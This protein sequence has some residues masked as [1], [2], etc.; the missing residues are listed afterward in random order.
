M[1]PRGPESIRLRKVV[2]PRGVGR[3]CRRRLAML[4]RL[5][6]R[7][8]LAGDPWP[9]L[10]LLPACEWRAAESGLAAEAVPQYVVHQPPRLQPG[11][12]PLAGTPADTGRDQIDI[13]WQT[14]TV[15]AGTSDDFLV[16]FRAPTDATWT[17]VSLNPVLD[18]GDDTRL[19]HSA[20]LRDLEWDADYDY[21]VDHRRLGALVDRYEH[22]FHTRLAT[23]DSRS[24]T[25]VAYGDSAAPGLLGDGFRAVQSRINDSDAAFAVLLGDNIYEFGTH[26]EAD[27][28]FTP[29][30]NLAA[31]SWIAGHVD[32]FA[33]G[34]HDAIINFH[35]GQPSRDSYSSPQPVAGLNAYAAPPAGEFPE[36]NYSWDYGDV[37][38]V[39]IDTNVV[40]LPTAADRLTRTRAM[41]DY[42]VAD[43][44]ASSARWKIVSTHHP[45]VGSEKSYD[46]PA[47]FY[48]QE[49]LPR[50]RAAGA[51]LLLAGD[52]HTYS[53]TYPL[54]GFSDANQDGQIGA[55]EVDYV[56]DPD[57]EY[58][59]GGGLIQLIAGVGG[60]SLRS[61]SYPDPFM[62]GRFSA[63]ASTGPIEY[64]FA[65]FAVTSEALTVSYISAATGQIVGD[66][67]ANGAADPDEPFFGQFRLVAYQRGD[68]D[69]D[70]QLSSLDL[71]LLCAAIHGRDPRPKHDLNADGQLDLIDYQQMVENVLR[72]RPGDANLDGEVHADDLVRVFVA[73]KYE[74]PFAAPAAW[75]EGDWNCDGLFT[76]SDLVLMLFY[77]YES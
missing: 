39:T 37:H 59:Q 16:S 51:D 71:D 13:L 23:N 21:R 47:S 62:A 77:G 19:I 12:V 49:A 76:S 22:S 11:N 63:H 31:T 66:T 55:H 24:F 4:E 53:W 15:A 69:G 56:A 65:H 1:R 10:S 40:E 54:K 41:L 64:G 14:R 44:Q 73:G 45:I 46:D 42:V 35:Q 26:A 68:F 7:C 25:F 61:H 67:N 18:T 70:G 29:Q 38:F 9:Q 32:Y 72:T 58:E 33:I 6:V 74:R 28:R 75:S 60:R 8:L 34:N 30:Q 27:A 48:F 2:K 17:F 50:L 3:S 43:L 20:T 52:S 57:R 5:E 36:H